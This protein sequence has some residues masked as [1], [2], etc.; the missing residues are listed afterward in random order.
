MRELINDWALRKR[1][2][3]GLRDKESE[4]F[5]G[6]IWVEANDW[7]DRIFEIGWFAEK[8]NMG[9]GCVTQAAKLSLDFIFEVLDAHKV[10]VTTSASNLRSFSVA[11][12]CGS[13][14]EGCLRQQKKLNDGGCRGTSS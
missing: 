11:D 9:K 12:R 1:F 7:K 10:A 8:G 5:V 6:E 14:R 13:I 4:M 2:V 3:L